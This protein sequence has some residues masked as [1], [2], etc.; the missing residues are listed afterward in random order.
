MADMNMFRD[1]QRFLRQALRCREIED[2]GSLASWVSRAFRWASDYGWSIWRPVI[3]LLVSIL[4][5][6]GTIWGIEHAEQTSMSDPSLSVG[7]ALGISFSNSFSFLGLSTMFLEQEM[8]SLSS[9][10]RII[11]GIQMF[12]GPILLFLLGLGLRNRLRIG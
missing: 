8:R 6:W 2:T 12:L 3:C 10:S 11:A 1:E 9:W 5:G 7:Q 4:V